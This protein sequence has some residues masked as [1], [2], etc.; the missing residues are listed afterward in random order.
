MLNLIKFNRIIGHINLC[1]LNESV[2]C[3]L[4][5]LGYRLASPDNHSYDSVIRRKRSI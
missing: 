2:Y 4:I 1:S 5:S 3:M